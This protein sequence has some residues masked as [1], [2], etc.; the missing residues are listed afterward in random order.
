MQFFP[1]LYV[2]TDEYRSTRQTVS[3]HYV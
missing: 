2:T 1:I 3:W